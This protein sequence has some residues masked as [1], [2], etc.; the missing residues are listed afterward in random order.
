MED[1]KPIFIQIK[2]FY[3]RLID[4]GALKEGEMMPSVR[5]VALL[6]NA[7]PNT[8]QRAFSLMVDDGYLISVPKKGFFIQKI[9]EDRLSILRKYLKELVNKG[10]TYQEI[11]KELEG[12]KDDHIKSSD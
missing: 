5:E 4:I 9:K 3:E 10:Y 6:N 12:M 11:E 7:N 2:D 8:V 1:K